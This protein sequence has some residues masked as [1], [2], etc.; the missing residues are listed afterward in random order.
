MS[1]INWKENAVCYAN[2]GQWVLSE[3]KTMLKCARSDS[4]VGFDW[5]LNQ[6]D[7]QLNEIKVGDYLPKSELDTEQKYNEVV[8]VFGLFGF[9][10][11]K[12][13]SKYIGMVN[14]WKGVEIYNGEVAN[15]SATDGRKLTYS[16]IMAIDKLKRMMLESDKSNYPEF[17]DSSKRNK[18]KQAYD[19]LKSL[20]YE[21]DLV[22]QRWYKKQYID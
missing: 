9:E 19:I 11:C 2:A 3:D 20:D 5:V 16:Q 4:W 8:E 17:P 10:P 1:D 14:Y 12:H 22:K 21:Y 18:S 6:H 15:T 7:F 13:H